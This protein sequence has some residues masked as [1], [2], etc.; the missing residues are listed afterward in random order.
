MKDDIKKNK[1]YNHKI[2][3]YFWKQTENLAVTELTN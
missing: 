2:F 1:E 3:K